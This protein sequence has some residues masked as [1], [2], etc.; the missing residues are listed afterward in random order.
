MRTAKKQ[1]KKTRLELEK[2][3]TNLIKE[4]GIDSLIVRD[5]FLFNFCKPERK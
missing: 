4:H 1:T 5:F 3:F 2:E